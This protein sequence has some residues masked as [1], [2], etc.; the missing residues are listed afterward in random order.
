MVC[1]PE[2]LVYEDNPEKIVEF[3]DDDPFI[4]YGESEYE[5]EP[6]KEEEDDFYERDVITGRKSKFNPLN[7]SKISIN[8][9]DDLFNQ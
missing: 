2:Y 6:V 9:L 7:S 5:E 3:E 1:D 4:D 8:E